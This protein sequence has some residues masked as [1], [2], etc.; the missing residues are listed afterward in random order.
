MTDPTDKMHRA[1]YRKVVW[2]DPGMVEFLFLKRS[3]RTRVY[4]VKRCSAAV[5]A[6]VFLLA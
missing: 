2:T 4:N 5:Q 6:H 3:E 1:V